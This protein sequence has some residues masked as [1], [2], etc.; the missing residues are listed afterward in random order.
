MRKHTLFFIILLFLAACSSQS[1]SFQDLKEAYPDTFAEPVESLSEEKQEKVGLPDDLPFE[2]T[3]VQAE[4]TEQE[5]MVHYQSESEEELTVKTLYAPENILQDSELQ[6]P[7]NSGSVAGVQEKED[8]VF[9]EWYESDLDV[10]YQLQYYGSTEERAEK[11]L[12]AA[13]AI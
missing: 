6:I 7:L 10:I 4:A 2:V 1:L 13:N 3:N 8:Y 12:E 5:V 9:V 11:A